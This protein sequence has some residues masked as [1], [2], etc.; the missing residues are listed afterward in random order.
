MAKI[1]LGGQNFNYSFGTQSGITWEL[2]EG[3]V[4]LQTGGRKKGELNIL[5]EQY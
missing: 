4:T 3:P 2:V 5:Q 1:T